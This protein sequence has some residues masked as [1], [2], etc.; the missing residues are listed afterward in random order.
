MGEMGTTDE[1]I[2]KRDMAWLY[3]AH[4]VVAEVTQPSLGV[5]YELAY[6]EQRKL[7]VLCLYRPEVLKSKG[8]RLSAMIKGS[9]HVE[10]RPYDTAEEGKA[11]IDQFLATAEAAIARS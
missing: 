9:P 5:G 11:A 7:P 3:S 2:Y 6:A 8:S 10:I 4:L 1:F